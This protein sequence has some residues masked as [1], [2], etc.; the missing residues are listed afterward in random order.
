MVDA[1]GALEAGGAGDGG[2]GGAVAAFAVP[3]VARAVTFETRME[4][5]TMKSPTGVGGQG[6]G[7]FKVG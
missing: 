5:K 4:L 1:S 2:G 3:G 7:S 6:E